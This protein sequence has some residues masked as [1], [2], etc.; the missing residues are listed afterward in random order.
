[1]HQP[2]T[3]GLIARV[4]KSTSGT[5]DEAWYLDSAASV[6]TTY[7][8]KNYIYSNLDNS[9]EDIEIAN[10]KVLR[11]R[12]AG[13]I[14]IEIVIDNIPSFIHIHN[15]HY[16]PEIDTNLLSLGVLASKCFKFH[17][18]KGVLNVIDAAENTVLQSRCKGQ[19][20]TLA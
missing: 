19:V 1:M 7:H 4:K 6:H 9:Q 17:T 16:C 2:K 11:T 12:R 5:K 18:K 8:L 3:Q 10:N 20:Y 13:T 15:V 14:A